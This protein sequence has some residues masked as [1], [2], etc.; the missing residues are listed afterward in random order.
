MKNNWK[1]SK[2]CDIED[3]VSGI[4]LN[5]NGNIYFTIG[6]ENIYEIRKDDINTN[7]KI[8]INIKGANLRGIVWNK[9]NNILY[10]C[11]YVNHKILSYS[12]DTGNISTFAGNGKEGYKDGNINDAQFC[13][14]K[15]ITIDKN[16]DLYITDSHHV[17][18]INISS[19]IVETIAGSTTGGYKDGEAKNAKL[20]KEIIK[21]IAS[22]LS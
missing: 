18:K 10:I 5:N 7:P 12:I 22:Y 6:D 4:T 14:P 11:D 2:L 21:E 3:W 15:G 1:V 13:N 19:R 8:L 20:P 17:R 9:N 16:G